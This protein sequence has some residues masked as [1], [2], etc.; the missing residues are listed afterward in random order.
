MGEEGLY[1]ATYNPNPAVI[2]KEFFRHTKFMDWRFNT[3]F[4]DGHANFTKYL[5]MEGVLNVSGADYTIDRNK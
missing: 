1:Y 3:S 5:Y 2:K 4:A